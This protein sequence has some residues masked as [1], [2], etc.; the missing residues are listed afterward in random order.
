M[1]WI[2]IGAVL[3]IAFLLG[4]QLFAFLSA[5]RVRG[6]QPAG[7][8]GPLGDAVASGRTVMAYF[9]SPSC[10]ACVRQTPVVERLRQEY[11]DVYSINVPED[12]DTARKLGV[13]GTPSIVL[14][15]GGIVK[16]FLLGYQPEARLRSL[17]SS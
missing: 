3:L 9:F 7:L 2:A 5:R 12:L 14:I 17:F 8:T 13:M 1:T 16:E 15:R 11:P 4:V 6:K 10:A